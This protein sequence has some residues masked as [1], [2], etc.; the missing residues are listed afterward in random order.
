MFRV[1]RC[2]RCNNIG[3]SRVETEDEASTCGLCQALILHEKGTVY[4]VTKSEALSLVRDLAL[5]AHHIRSRAR[6]ATVRGLGVK[7]RVYNIIEAL[8]DLK[9]GK[10]VSIEE[11]MRE[12]SEAGIELGRAMKFID[13]LESEGFII[14]DGVHIII[15]EGVSTGV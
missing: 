15:I 13:A 9:R 6:G 7:K 2:S 3:Y 14:N 11:V 10:P 4:A 5:E 8:I 1:Y 12:C